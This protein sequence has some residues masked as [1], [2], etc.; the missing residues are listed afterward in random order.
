MVATA[1]QATMPKDIIR[2]IVRGIY[3]LQK[4]RI[5]MGNRI[6]ANFRTK[7]GIL[8]SKKEDTGSED[9]KILK[10]LRKQWRRVTD[11][12]VSMPKKMMEQIELDVNGTAIISGP[13]ENVLISQ[14]INILTEE[15]RQFRDL[16]RIVE[17]HPLWDAFLKDVVGVGPAMAGVIL[18]EIDIYQA[19]YVSSIWAYA[20]LDVVTKWHLQSTTVKRGNMAKKQPTIDIPTEVDYLTEDDECSIVGGKIVGME[21]DMADQ[22]K[23]VPDNPKAVD[24]G[25]VAVV[26]FNRDGY[27]VHATYRMFHY[28][29]RSRRQDHLTTKEYTDKEGNLQT[30]VSITFNPWLKTKLLGVLADQFNR[31]PGEKYG[32]ILVDYKHR[33]KNMPRHQDKSAGHIHNM[34][35]RY[36]VKIFLQDL[37]NVWRR[38][39]GL[40]VHPPY[41][42]AKLGLIHEEGEDRKKGASRKAK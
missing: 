3:D 29:G 28:G 36:A 11:G 27:L 34:A 9:A 5:Q 42:E 38:L 23:A 21:F 18:S 14:Y 19:K 35:K 2:S 15:E 16:S 25:T 13:A 17:S 22:P 39:E 26:E 40:E 10:E 20:G 31:R 30:K 6:V 7:L 37:Y 8:P 12:V 33:L 1:Q 32:K 4:N 24:C 41:H